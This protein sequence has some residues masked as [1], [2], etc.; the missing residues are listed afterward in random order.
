MVRERTSR[1]A[2]SSTQR[3]PA[4][5]G[6]RLQPKHASRRA[7]DPRRADLLEVLLPG[8][9]DQ[10]LHVLPDHEVPRVGASAQLDLFIFLAAVAAGTIARRPDRRS[11]RT[12]GGD[13]GARSSACCR[14]RSLLPHAN[15][16]WTRVLTVVIGLILASAFSAII[17]YAQ[18]LVPGTQSA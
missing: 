18:E 11:L 6:T 16:F 7:R 17:V 10:L 15:L 12:Q 5:A 9:P 13:L 4:V 8:E 1:R 3:A 2:V 14:S